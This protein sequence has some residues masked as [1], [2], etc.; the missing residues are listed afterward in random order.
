M[1]Q[2]SW[3][4]RLMMRILNHQLLNVI[5][6]ASLGLLGCSPRQ[7]ESPRVAPR[8]EKYATVFKLKPRTDRYSEAQNV[9]SVLP[10]CPIIYEQDIGTG[11]LVSSEFSK[12]TY[13]LLES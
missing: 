6:C 8:L 11:I 12:P 5:L 10:T 2:D 1:S 9:L 4:S 13:F 3:T 7:K